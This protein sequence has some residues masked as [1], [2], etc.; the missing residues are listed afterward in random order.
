MGWFYDPHV[1]G[2]IMAGG[3]LSKEGRTV[4]YTGDGVHF[5]SFS[6]PMP[7]QRKL[8]CLV[9]LDDQVP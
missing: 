2:L 5:N 6:A 4:Y 7:E 1:Y 8:P 3:H 9:V